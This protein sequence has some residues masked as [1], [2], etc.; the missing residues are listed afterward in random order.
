MCDK[1]VQSSNSDSSSSPG[2]L[3]QEKK[4][5]TITVTCIYFHQILALTYV[6]TEYILMELVNQNLLLTD[7]LMTILLTM[8]INRCQVGVKFQSSAIF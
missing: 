1:T 5:I 7:L 4:G 3:D 8:D 6:I 2:S